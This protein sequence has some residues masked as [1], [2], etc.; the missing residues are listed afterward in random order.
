MSEF[1]FTKDEAA[2]LGKITTDFL[3]SYAA[4]PE[5]MTNYE[6][7]SERFSAYLPDKSPEEIST[8]SQEIIS[9]LE[10]QEEK[11]KSLQDSLAQGISKESWFARETQKALSGFS[12][13]ESAKYLQN[14]DEAVNTANAELLKTILKKDGGVSMNKNLDGFIAEEMHSQTFNLNAAATGSEFRAR[15]L[16]PEGRF[17][18]NSV[19]NVIEDAAGKI[20]RKYQLKY[21]QNEE[22]SRAMYEAGDYRGQRFL[23]PEGKM[24]A[25][26]GTSSNKFSKV[27]AKDLQAKAQKGKW[28][29][30]LSWNDFKTKDIALGI[31]KET[32]KAGAMGLLAGA[33]FELARQVYADEKIDGEKVIEEGLKG[34]ADFGIKTAAAGALKTA[35]EKGVLNILPKGTPA[36]VYT[37]IAF[38][39][40]EG[41]KV[42]GDVASGEL[43]P[44]EGY[45]KIE[46]VTASSVVGLTAASKGAAIGASV[47]SCLGP[48][49]SAVGGFIGG[50]VGYVAGS[51]V[52]QAVVKGVQK[53]RRVAGEVVKKAWEG[54]KSVG[55]SISRAISNIFS[56]F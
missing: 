21:G 13:E 20:T 32:G 6:W 19:D 36:G 33:G 52:A 2:E 41:V 24:Q 53:V 9:G 27:Q 12:A 40:V 22:A 47:L 15:T 50:T 42:L 26:D 17:G 28:E 14:L 3:Q 48:V 25:P 51:G 45:E 55:R 35:S 30:P 34:G 5:G 8:I 56:W 7:L 38:S 37:T 1:E 4:K 29:D 46:E 43:T 31:A 11:K 16:H 10:T 49:G 39:A 54:V 23:G 44:F 18:K